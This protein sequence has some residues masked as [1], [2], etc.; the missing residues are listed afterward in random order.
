[1][2]KSFSQDGYAPASRIHSSG[3]QRQQR[4][5]VSAAGSNETLSLMQGSLSEDFL[6]GSADHPNGFQ[7]PLSA[8]FSSSTSFGEEPG[9]NISVVNYDGVLLFPFFPF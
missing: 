6:V 9:R 5:A 7:S 3:L 1:M 4:V 2:V 8:K